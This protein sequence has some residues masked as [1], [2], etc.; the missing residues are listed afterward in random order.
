MKKNTDLAL[1]GIC[2]FAALCLPADLNASDYYVS[3]AGDDS[4]SGA[5][6]APWK[7][8]QQSVEK[9]LPGDTLHLRSGTYYESVQF[10][11]SGAHGS[12]ISVQAYPG[13]APIIDGS[14]LEPLDGWF[15]LIK[16]E[17]VS[18]ISVSGLEL[19]DLSASDQDSVPIGILVSGASSGVKIISN[20]VHHIE[21]KSVGKDGGNAHGI[22]VYGTDS[23]NS[24]DGIEIRGNIVSDC[25]LGWS[26]SMV[27][28][29]NVENFVVSQNTVRDNDNIGIDLIGWEGTAESNDQ[30]RNG[31]VSENTVF[32]IS[33]SGNPAYGGEAAAAGIYVDGGKDITI[34]RNS[35]SLCDFGVEVGCENPG[36]TTSGIIVRSN[37]FFRNKVTGIGF[38]GYDTKRGVTI[39]CSFMHNTLFENDSSRSGTGEIMIQVAHSNRIQNNIVCANTQNILISNWFAKAYSH[40]NQFDNNTYYCGGA[41]EAKAIFVW[42]NKEYE[43]FQSYVSGSGEDAAS[44]FADPFFLSS[45]DDL[46]VHDSSP[47]VDGGDPAFIASPGEKDYAGADRL[48]GPR[49][50]CGAFEKT[51]NFAVYTYIAAG[52][53]FKVDASEIGE[54]VFEAPPKLFGILAGKTIPAA[55]LRDGFDTDPPPGS[56]SVMWTRNV[57]LYDKKLYSRK[58]LLSTLLETPI[59][60]RIFDRFSVEYDGARHF[61][62]SYFVFASP[63]IESAA[64]DPKDASGNT[65]LVA[66]KYFGAVPPKIYV[67]YLKNG[68]AA[69]PGYLRCKTDLSSSMIFQDAKRREGK[70]C[71]LIHADDPAADGKSPGYSFLRVLLP[72][73]N[74]KQIGT[75]YIILDNSSGLARFRFK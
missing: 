70:S 15:P 10:T 73:M 67:E 52:S 47:A 36:R 62:D 71:M 4:A 50:D 3:P 34:E 42:N 35:V 48:I 26:E 75:G 66:G 14:K 33:S 2:A 68:A 7:S 41:D 72:K 51:A 17:N 49:S 74:S 29:G 16:I 6:N 54:N 40:D 23:A 39:N 12:P 21:Q 56:I 28:N 46:R 5:E 63:T 57:L 38:G 43:G 19:K 53:L 20:N 8:L 69:S 32:G 13:E 61:L 58:K 27:L 64:P 11:K 30:A 31:M 45:P 25:K 9:L 59:P 1:F 37:L 44:V 65:L 55:V 60:D 24:I 18:H 22:A